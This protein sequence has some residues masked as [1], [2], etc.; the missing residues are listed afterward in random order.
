MAGL[1]KRCTLAGL[2][3]IAAAGVACAGG[4]SPSSTQDKD[5]FQLFQR[6]KDALE[7]ND[8]SAAF[9]AYMMALVRGDTDYQ[10]FPP[11]RQGQADPGDAMRAAA[12]ELSEAVGRISED[13]QSLAAALATLTA[14]DP[15]VSAGY[16]PGWKTTSRCKDYLAK[17]KENKA[18]YLKPVEDQS[19]LLSLPDYFKAYKVYKG[20]YRDYDSPPPDDAYSPDRVKAADNAKETILRIEK[21]K[22][23]YFMTP[24]LTYDTEQPLPFHV[25]ATGYSESPISLPG[26]YL[27]STG[28]D[29]DTDVTAIR[30]EAAYEKLWEAVY[31][32]KKSAPTRPKVD[33]STHIVVAAALGAR[34]L[35]SSGLFIN[36][37]GFT[38]Y[39][40]N[41]SVYLRLRITAQRCVKH[42]KTVYPFTIV[43]LAKPAD[44]VQANGY[45][46]QSFYADGC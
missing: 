26:S 10:C 34:D 33:F 25:I 11:A 40:N 23:V 20:V 38:S 27:A 31:P 32:D 14:W 44:G 6:A 18:F 19:Q 41:L 7:H 29:T 22:G 1:L 13:P 4:S 12:F 24:A 28:A 30:D 42:E 21:S 46:I 39:F 5:N 2:F 15:S 9:I 35:A 45:D 37:I 36:R 17:A 8:L 3:L 43:T 16:E